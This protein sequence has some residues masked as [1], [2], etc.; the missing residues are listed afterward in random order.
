M[1]KKNI[2]A[3][4]QLAQKSLGIRFKNPDYLLAAI[5]HPSYRNENPAIP[6]EDFDRLEFFGDAILNYAI[7]RRLYDKFE[8]ANEG[9]LSRLRSILVSRK[10]LL[11]VALSLGLTRFVRLGRSLQDQPD[12]GKSKLVSDCFEAVIAA[13]YFDQG[14]EKAEKFIWTHMKSYFDSKKLFRLD[15]NPKST[16]QEL[17]LKHWKKLPV[18][19]QKIT[20]AG[21]KIVLTLNSRNRTSAIAET[22][23]EAEERAA[24]QLI[25][26]VRQ[27][28]SRVSKTKSSGR[29]L[30]KTR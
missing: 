23:R 10:I 19:D 28:L 29:K 8:D 6:L 20:P 25:R 26:I 22:R 5:S 27:N 18:Y 1:S 2:N 9:L 14:L 24:R 12:I 11:R 30:R 16:L 3:L 21:I 7:C 4:V 13:I 15:P 17:T